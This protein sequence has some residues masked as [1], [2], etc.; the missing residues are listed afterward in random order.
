[1][2]KRLDHPRSDLRRATRALELRNRLRRA[3]IV[4]P[5][6]EISAA[7][8]AHVS[9]WARYKHYFCAILGAL[10]GGLSVF[11]VTVLVDWSQTVDSKELAKRTGPIG[12][13]VDRSVGQA[14]QLI[15]MLGGIVNEKYSKPNLEATETSSEYQRCLEECASSI[16]VTEESDKALLADCRNECISRYSK[17]VKEIRKPFIK[18]QDSD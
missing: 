18:G 13:A 7:R 1:V 3:T 12:T 2:P 14:D 17:S 11:A 9:L 4:M 10:V 8:S 16:R 6:T 15:K 5:E